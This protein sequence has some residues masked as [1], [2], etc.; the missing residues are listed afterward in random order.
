MTC[1]HC[2]RD[3]DAPAPEVRFTGEFPAPSMAELARMGTMEPKGPAPR[4]AG[5]SCS[6]CGKPASAVKKLLTGRDV[7]IC[8]ECVALCYMVL[9]DE[10]PDFG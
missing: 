2:G 5:D 6:W 1:P 4:A 8:N 9:R 10:L 3:T 7:Q